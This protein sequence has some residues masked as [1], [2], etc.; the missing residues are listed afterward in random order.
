[1]ANGWSFNYKKVFLKDNILH[2]Y[3]FWT[4]SFRTNAA[5]ECILATQ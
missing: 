4:K 3:G 5:V 2:Y 1:M